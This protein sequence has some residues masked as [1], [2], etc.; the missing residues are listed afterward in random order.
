MTLHWHPETPTGG[1]PGPTCG[2]SKNHEIIL[3]KHRLNRYFMKA[4]NCFFCPYTLSK[5]LL[6]ADSV[7]S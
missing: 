4:E 3:D 5:E 7:L 6:T 1:F 2:F